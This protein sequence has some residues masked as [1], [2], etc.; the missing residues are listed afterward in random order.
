VIGTTSSTEGREHCR[1]GRARHHD[2]ERTAARELTGA[3]RH[4]RV[5]AGRLGDADHEHH[6]CQQPD[7]VEVDGLDRLLLVD[8]LRDQHDGRAEQRHLRPIDPLARDH[9][10][11]GNEDPDC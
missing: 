2:R 7:R 10:E 9:G 11:R 6:A 4:P 1:G 5:Y 3:D 8:R